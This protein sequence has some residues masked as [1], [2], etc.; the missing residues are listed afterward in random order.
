M[1]KGTPCIICYY[2]VG[3]KHRRLRVLSSALPAAIRRPHVPAVRVNS[4]S[5]I[6]FT[7]VKSHENQH[8]FLQHAASIHTVKCHISLLDAI[9][10]SPKVNHATT[11]KPINM[12]CH[13]VVVDIPNFEVVKCL[14]SAHIRNFD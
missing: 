3:P 14:L 13:L 5:I 10:N 4:S 11:N 8:S 6:L 12:H 2:F 7:S 9:C 1:T